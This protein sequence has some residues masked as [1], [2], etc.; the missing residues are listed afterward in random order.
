MLQKARHICMPSRHANI[1]MCRVLQRAGDLITSKFPAFQKAKYPNI[2][3][4]FCCLCFRNPYILSKYF[5]Y[6]LL[7]T[8]GSTEA[9]V[10][11]AIQPSGP[12]A[13][14]LARFYWGGRCSRADLIYWF[15]FREYVED[16]IWHSFLIYQKKCCGADLILTSYSKMLGLIWCWFLIWRI[17]WGAD[18]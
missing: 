1:R 6:L 3:K 11:E 16:L 17:R 12:D 8:E 5:K 13:S 7:Q 10:R 2:S 18:L 15:L 9:A 4:I 14:C